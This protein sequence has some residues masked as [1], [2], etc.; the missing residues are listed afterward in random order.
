MCHWDRE[1]YG[2]SLGQ[3]GTWCVTGTGRNRVCHWDREERGVSLGQGG[4]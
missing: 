2:V 4:T 3:G 1:E